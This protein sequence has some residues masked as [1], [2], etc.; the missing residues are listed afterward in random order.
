MNNEALLSPRPQNPYCHQTSVD[1]EDRD[2]TLRAE[3]QGQWRPRTTGRCPIC[4]V[5]DK[6]L[7]AGGSAEFRSTLLANAEG[8]IKRYVQRGPKDIEG[9]FTRLPSGDYVWRFTHDLFYNTDEAFQA[10]RPPA[11]ARTPAARA[12]RDSHRAEVARSSRRRWAHRPMRRGRVSRGVASPRLGVRTPVGASA[13]SPLAV[14]CGGSW[15]PAPVLLEGL[16][17]GARSASAR[18]RCP[19]VAS[20]SSSCRPPM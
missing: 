11:P 6:A 16:A 2:V 4:L 7:G 15:C 10:V 3:D 1:T 18:S 20:V 14:V 12:E 17:G 9:P 13:R 19:R 8:R 5:V